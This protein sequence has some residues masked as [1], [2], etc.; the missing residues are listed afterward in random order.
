HVEPDEARR[1]AR[2]HPAT[3]T[4]DA[5]VAASPSPT[6]P[7]AAVPAA[8]G[9]A[10]PAIAPPVPSFEAAPPSDPIVALTRPCVV[11]R[12]GHVDCW[13]NGTVERMRDIDDAIA[14]RVRGGHARCVL[15]RGGVDCDQRPHGWEPPRF[16]GLI[17]P[18]DVMPG[19]PLCV[20]ER[21][22]RVQCIY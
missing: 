4:G 10:A 2:T 8:T 5:A 9:P 12:S 20:L 22:G 7:T 21:A 17:D 14:V 15:R 1:A 11:R 19:D 13:A 16:P 6:G 18:I 3:A